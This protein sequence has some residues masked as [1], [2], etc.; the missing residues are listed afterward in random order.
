MSTIAWLLLAVVAVFAVMYF[1]G[2][3]VP[4]ISGTG[5]A[6]DAQGRPVAR[7]NVPNSNQN[8]ETTIAADIGAAFTLATSIFN[9]QSDS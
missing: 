9:S 1:M 8:L 5:V 7:A 2:K 6:V 4:G 3:K